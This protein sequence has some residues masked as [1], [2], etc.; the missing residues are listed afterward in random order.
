MFFT[1]LVGHHEGDL[2]DNNTSLQSFPEPTWKTVWLTFSL[3]AMIWWNKN[4]EGNSYTSC[5]TN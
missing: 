1:L 3:L 2:V 5:L 4:D